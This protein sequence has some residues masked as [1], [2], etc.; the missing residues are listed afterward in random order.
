MQSKWLRNSFNEPSSS[1][2]DNRKNIFLVLGEMPTNKGVG[3]AQKKF[4]INFIKANKQVSLSLHYN[5]D[6]SGF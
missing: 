3:T 4:S 2:I 6:E 1:H 5:D